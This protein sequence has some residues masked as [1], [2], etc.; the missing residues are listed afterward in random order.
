MRWI[1]NLS[2]QLIL[3]SQRKKIFARLK[4]LFYA[5]AFRIAFLSGLIFLLLHKKISFQ[6]HLQLS[7][8][9]GLP[10]LDAATPEG[11]TTETFNLGN[12]LKQFT[13]QIWED[14]VAAPEFRKA[15]AEETMANHFHYISAVLSPEALRG[16]GVTEADLTRMQ[17]HCRAYVNRFAP[18]A[19]A[20]MKK[21]GIPAS[22]KL[23]QALLESD[24]GNSA[25][26]KKNN[27]HFGIK[28]FSSKCSAGHCSNFTDDS[29]KDFFRNFEN[30]WA[31]FRAHSLL[32]QNKRY[33]GLKKIPSQH[34][35]EWAEE[36]QRAGYATDKNYAKKLVG[37]VEKL[38]LFKFDQ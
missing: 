38:D 14:A 2:Q 24:A 22:I 4:P 32:L 27:N 36:L 31:S 10:K 7:P 5:H 13:E 3:M 28:C 19:R 6:V 9:P 37:I 34:Y 21:F 18:V 17:E 26:S 20:E 25:L 15:A 29:H 1:L 23:A 33:Q 11:I 16:R 30:A 8:Q 12:T 35:R